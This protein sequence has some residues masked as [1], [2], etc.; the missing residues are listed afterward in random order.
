M[1]TR[2][3][4]LLT[5]VAL[6][7]GA[8]F[9]LDL[10]AYLSFE[11][12]QSQ[13]ERIV[14]AYEADPFE[15]AAIFL[16]AYVMI[17]GL[18]LPFAA[19]M[20]IAA[21]AIF[22]LWVAVLIVSFASTIGATIA[23]LISRTLLRD[24]VQRRFGAQ[25]KLINAGIERDG[26]FYLFSIRMVPLFPFIIVNLVM[27]LT[28]MRTGS[29]YVSSQLGMLAGTVVY[30]FA[31]TQVAQLQSAGDL[32]SPGL[33][34]AFAALGLF[35]LLA[36]R[37][38]S[39]F[40]GRKHLAGFRKPRHFDNNLIVIGAGSAG[41]IASLIA[42]TVKAKVT[43]I[44]RHKMGG[45]CLH[46][47]CVPSKTLLRSARVANTVLEASRYGINAGVPHVDFPAV[48][49]RV[50][51]VIRR[52]E[53]VDSVERYTSLGVDCIQGDARL[54][55]PWTVE[56]DG[57]RITARAIILAAGAAPFVPPIPGIE[58][59]DYLTSDTVWDLSALPGRLLVMGAGP[60]GCELAQAFR[61]L[62]SEVTL[63]DMMDRVLP[64]EDPEISDLVR[65]RFVEEGIRV[66]TAHR[67]T[68]FHRGED[69]C[70][71]EV[72]HAGEVS[73]IAFDRVLVAVGRKASLEG[74]ELDDLHVDLTPAGTVA[75]DDYMRSSVPTIYACGDV[76]GPYQF[77]HMAS[78][79]AWFAAVNALFGRFWRFRVN[80]SVV[81]W[82]TY[83]DPEVARVGLSETQ[84]TDEGVAF[85]VTRL[86]LRES[87]R[88]LT[89]GQ[90]AGF[91][92]VLTPPGSD[93][94]LGAT[95]V[96]AHAGE[97][98]PE[99]IL[100]MTHGLGLKKI[101]GAIHVYPTLSEANKGAANAWRRAHAP[102]ALLGFVGR[103]H[104]MMR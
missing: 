64:R 51:E 36:R 16:A 8:F 5:I 44:E 54:V 93:R 34:G 74:L 46:T 21:G 20:T 9:L 56:V 99:F 38:V 95:I 102:E 42:A 39:A 32:V 27:A 12:F 17:T 67:A 29:F 85:E 79:Q 33:L 104:A 66:Y 3:I 13:R 47:G 14:G 58:E 37:F 73:E 59:V 89:D 69:T 48:M 6:A 87:D 22:G 97:M 2:Q 78:H 96:G 41:L 11:Y 72:E 84:A 23:F 19:V 7:I 28:P 30:V 76:T 70:V 26:S 43:L 24:W 4:V 83:T 75:V 77:T 94:I 82:V 100:A 35:P 15:V 86:D 52:I 55:D 57:R 63:V 65:E 92:K 50:R 90:E 80:Y 61:R 49:E 98:L 71:L 18:S 31:G 62:G 40:A 45:D 60:I 68:A 10:Q 81:P 91:V 25:L 88:A 53:P 103:F 1:S 101:T